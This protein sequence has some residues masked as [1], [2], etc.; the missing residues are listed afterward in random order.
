MY[1]YETKQFIAKRIFVSTTFSCNLHMDIEKLLNDDIN[2]HCIM[3]NPTMV[4]FQVDHVLMQC[5]ISTALGIQRGS[6]LLLAVWRL[7]FCA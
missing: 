7:D 1:E 3:K 4:V 2:S 6:K 5:L